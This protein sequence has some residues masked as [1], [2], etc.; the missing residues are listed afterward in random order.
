[1]KTYAGLVRLSC[2][3]KSCKKVKKNIVPECIDCKDVK[4]EILDL[5]NKPL[6]RRTKNG[7]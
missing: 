7:R 2:E 5:E 4:V 3:K 1:M 6:K